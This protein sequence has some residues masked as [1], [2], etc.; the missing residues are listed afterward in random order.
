MDSLLNGM[1]ADWVW[2]NLM[3]EQTVY[4]DEH[5]GSAQILQPYWPA[6]KSFVM[7]AAMMMLVVMAA[8]VSVSCYFYGR[9]QR[10]KEIYKISRIIGLYMENDVKSGMVFEAEYAP[11]ETQL[12]SAKAKCSIIS[13]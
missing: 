3:Q 7:T 10:K 6:I 4:V 13:R 8:A 5:T 9:R 1:F 12:V 11:V 2:E